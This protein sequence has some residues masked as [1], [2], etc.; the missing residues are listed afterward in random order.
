MGYGAQSQLLAW[1][2]NGHVPKKKDGEE[3]EERGKCKRPR[4]SWN[5]SSMKSIYPNINHRKRKE[6]ET[7]VGI[8]G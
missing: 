4:S 5:K 6:R 7:V 2:G 8:S 1:G 3:R